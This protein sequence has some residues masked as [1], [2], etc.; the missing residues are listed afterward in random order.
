MDRAQELHN[1]ICLLLVFRAQSQAQEANPN[2]HHHPEGEYSRVR[3]A[4]EHREQSRYPARVRPLYFRVTEH[5]K[6]RRKPNL[7]P[8]NGDHAPE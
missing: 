8:E 7:V 6:L 2:S 4:P 5:K 1:A 3:L